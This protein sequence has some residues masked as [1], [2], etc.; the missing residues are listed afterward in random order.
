MPLDWRTVFL[1]FTRGLSGK[2]DPRALQAPDL[3]VCRDAVFSE[4]GGTQTRHPFAALSSASA[5]TDGRRIVVNGDELLLFTKEALFSWSDRDGGWVSKGTYLAPKLEEASVF[6]RTTEQTQCDRAELDSCIV[7]SWLD[8]GAAAKVYIAAID[9]ATG[10]VILAPRAMEAGSSRP[11]LIALASKILLFYIVNGSTA[12]KV[13]SLD[14]DNL[15]T[16]AAVTATSVSTAANLYYDVTATAT[17]AVVV[18]RRQVTTSYS[19]ATVSA[20]PAVVLSATPARVCDG[21]IAVA[22]S[23]DGTRFQVVRGDALNVKGDLLNATTLAD[24]F[25]NQA[26]GSIGGGTL[27]QFAAAYRSVQNS[28]AYRC[29][30]WWS[31]TEV[32]AS[33]GSTNRN[34]VTTSN[35][36]GTAAL[37][38]GHI[39]IGSRAFDRDGEVFVWLLFGASTLNVSGFVAQLQNAYYLFRDDDTVIAKGAM[40]RASGFSGTIGHLPNVQAVGDDTFVFCGAERRIVSLSGN[41]AGYADR[42]PRSIA[43][44]FDSDESRRCVRLG[45]TL[46]ITGGQILQYDGE[47]L[48]EVGFHVFPYALSVSD[49]GAGTMVA[50]AFSYKPSYRWDNAKG[51]TERSTTAAIVQLTQVVNREVI[52]EW[53][54]TDVTMKKGTGHGGTRSPIACELWR[55]LKDPTEEA[56]F[57]L[58]TNPDPSVRTGDNAYEDNNA[59]LC[60]IIDSYSDAIAATKE[61][62]YENGGVLENLSPPAAS[63]IAATQD[64]V[65]LAGVSGDPDRIWYSKLRGQGEIAAF[66]DALTV[67]VPALG[68][69]ITALAFFDETLVVFRETAIYALPGDGFDNASGGQNYGPARRLSADV[70]ALSAETVAVTPGGLVFKSLKG[71]YVLPRGGV[72]E[73]IGAQVADFDED[74]VVAVTVLEAEH[75]IRCLTTERLLMFDYLE[76]QWA[77][78]TISGG[79]DA[80]IWG[81]DYLYATSTNVLVEQATFTGVT[82]GLDVETAWLPMA[83]LLQGAGACRWAMVLGEPRSPHGLRLRIAYNLKTDASG[84]PIWVDDKTFVSAAETVGGTLQFRHGPRFRKCEAIKFRLTACSVSAD[85]SPPTG[86]ALKLTGLSLE[87]GFRPGLYRG[88]SAA[89]KQ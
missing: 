62:N 38:S 89:Q 79:I 60:G 48:A 69:A 56:P 35:A 73:Y 12:L 86:E 45:E 84:E 71:W 53:G 88:L 70:G 10:A 50:G 57:Y 7:Y 51:E 6:V 58:V 55:T 87:L 61:T 46:Y 5:F 20:A 65:F 13:V 4:S 23:P 3:A 85:G 82:Y 78:W 1:P 31:D 32:A 80:A 40:Q 74:E 11:R 36:L 64:R 72:P 39:G 18:W 66:H 27:Y 15:A 9:R 26:I 2:T 41:Q 47:G 33:G 43:V 54:Q 30:V 24:V 37:V 77:E 76:R 28:G 29:Y 21:P 81:G 52:A 67:E 17:E 44:T 25:I 49:N 75:Q 42:G 59:G 8:T 22:V 16:S 63:I 68:G 19:V 34:Y 14:P 83:D